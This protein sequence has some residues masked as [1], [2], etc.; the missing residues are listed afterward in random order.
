MLE[1][2][3]LAGSDHA[4]AFE[5]LLMFGWLQAIISGIMY[6]VLLSQR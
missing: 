5:I 2:E 3:V 6:H 4:V 1:I